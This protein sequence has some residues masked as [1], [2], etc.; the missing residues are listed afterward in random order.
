MSAMRPLRDQRPQNFQELKQFIAEGRIFLPHQVEQVARRMLE[1][2]DMIAFE[3]AAA[4][5]KNCGVSQ[6]TVMRLS[7]LLGLGSYRGLKKLCA[8][9]VRERSKGISHPH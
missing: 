9:Y 3:S 8:S 6:T 4:V 1:Q 2:P 7:S 5:A